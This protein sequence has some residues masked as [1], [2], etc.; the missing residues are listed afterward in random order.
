MGQTRLIIIGLAIVL[1]Q[2]A[3]ASAEGLDLPPPPV[4]VE[5][6]CATCAGPIYLKGFI[7]AANPRVGDIWFEE[8]EFNDFQFFHKDIKNSALFGLGV[9]YQFNSWLRFDATGE[10]R[11]RSAFFAQDRYPGGNGT[12]NVESNELDGTFLPGTNEYTADIESWLGLANA[13]LDLGTYWCIT[14]YVG[15]GLGFA[16]ISVLGL[17]DVNVPNLGVAYATDHSETN[18]AWAVYAGLA[19]DVTPGFAIELSLSLCRSRRYQER[20]SDRLRQFLH[21]RRAGAYQ[22]HHLA[23][24]DAWRALEA[25]PPARRCSYAGRVQVTHPTALPTLPPVASTGGF[26]LPVGRWRRRGA[27]GILDALIAPGLRPA[28]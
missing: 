16:S 6:V 19:Y 25:R 27:L 11:G 21:Q 18:F 5:P 26:L 20:Q 2:T 10:Y 7:G 3:I 8:M 14:P 1:G 28:V 4:M 15:G 22:R 17:K 9:G 13:Y 24:P 23:R 12:F